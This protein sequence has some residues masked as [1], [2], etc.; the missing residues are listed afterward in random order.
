MVLEQTSAHSEEASEQAQVKMEVK[1]GVLYVV[2]IP[3]GNLDDFTPR[4]W[5]V[6]ENVDYIACEEVQASRR[7]LQL[8]KIKAQLISYRE[9]GR[10]EAGERILELL[11][12]NTKVALIAGAGT[13]AISD[14]GR[15]LVERCYAANLPISP[16]PGVSALTT[17]LSAAGLPSR[18][19]AFE[20]FLPRQ[21]GE[22]KQVL[23]A[24]ADEERTMVFFEAPHRLVDT[25]QAMLNSWGN[26]R[27][28]VGR[29]LTKYF[30]ECCQADLEFFC[31][32]YQKTP[33][34]GEFVIVVEGAQ[35]NEQDREL[36]LQKQLAE[37]T[38]FLKAL[39]LPARTQA[40][41]LI[42]FRGLNKNKAKKL[43]INA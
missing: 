43:T 38:A 10:E 16:I 26:R 34:K 11:R 41:L 28:F 33:P 39:N 20:G 17:A 6:L 35:V 13:P 27:A 18:R 37:D 21:S 5:H 42:H 2:A 4:A 24:L 23:Q 1:P 14:P 7:L 31:N 12:K 29:E 8:H 9:S 36:A 19:F 30:E 32:K 40:E 25:L 22:C 15:D 3:I